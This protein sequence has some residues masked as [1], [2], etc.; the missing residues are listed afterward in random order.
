MSDFT[1]TI[2]N[3]LTPS[4]WEK[5]SVI[6]ISLTLKP[7]LFDTYKIKLNKKATASYRQKDVLTYAAF[8][9]FHNHPKWLRIAL[10]LFECLISLVLKIAFFVPFIIFGF[11]FVFYSIAKVFR[12]VISKFIF[13]ENLFRQIFHENPNSTTED[14]NEHSFLKF[15]ISQTYSKSNIYLFLKPGDTLSEVYVEYENSYT[16]ETDFVAMKDISIASKLN[17]DL[18]LKPQR[19]DID[20][21]T[22]IS[23]VF[24]DLTAFVDVIFKEKGT[25]GQKTYMCKNVFGIVSFKIDTFDHYNTSLVYGAYSCTAENRDAIFLKMLK[26]LKDEAECFVL[27]NKFNVNMFLNQVNGNEISVRSSYRSYRTYDNIKIVHATSIEK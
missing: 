16:G 9:K 18:M 15:W 24:K 5:L 14:E 3:T 8:Y 13:G 22:Y 7:L 1:Y 4:V 12:N 25:N 27:G 21:N 11:V 2:E 19:I 17:L 26:I 6:I 20:E 10:M 23:V